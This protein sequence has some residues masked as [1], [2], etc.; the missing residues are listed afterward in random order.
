MIDGIKDLGQNVKGY[1]DRFDRETFYDSETGGILNIPVPGTKGGI[2]GDEGLE[3]A[4]FGE[5]GLLFDPSDPLDYITLGLAATGIGIPAAIGIKALT[6]GNKIRKVAS[7]AGN[8]VDR[9][10]IPRD[11]STIGGKAR[12][13]G[14]FVAA[15]EA[16]G[17]PSTI[18]DIKELRKIIEENKKKELEDRGEFIVTPKKDGGI[19]EGI[20]SFRKGGSAVKQALDAAKK[21]GKEAG[22][23]TNTKKTNTS[24]AD[25]IDEGTGAGAG[26][27]A[28]QAGQNIFQRNKG[29]TIAAGLAGVTAYSLF[30]GGDEE[31]Q[32][33]ISS[34]VSGGDLTYS[35]LMNA[36]SQ[37]LGNRI[38]TVG[39]YMR[40]SLIDD[41]G[42]SRNAQGGVGPLYLADENGVRK[43]ENGI[44]REKPSFGE[45]IKSFG[46]GYGQRVAN[47]PDFAKSMLAGFAAMMSPREGFA[48]LSPLGIPEFTAGYLA[49]EAISDKN[50]S[51]QQKL[52]EAV[53]ED[54][55]LRRLYLEGQAAQGGFSLNQIDYDKMVDIIEETAAREA[56][57]L[58][59]EG[60]DVVVGFQ[61]SDRGFIEMTP[62]KLA[63]LANQDPNI[64]YNL[65][66]IPKSEL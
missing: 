46:K 14:R 64:I 62:N 38:D 52:L 5:D 55:S 60:R 54:P 25:P 29:K 11:A 47:D 53:Q 21:E 36:G 12:N 50:K 23:K 51:A 15:E 44:E 26:A 9:T 1:G 16:V 43:P 63:A 4:M 45:Y 22:K 59:L 31:E 24:K 37:E 32:K 28:G 57:R 8:V 7:K 56:T 33:A 10:F 35:E 65:T 27:D 6:T 61:T 3:L 42:Y 48:P 49:Q 19:I 30:T 18:K 39:E 34:Q 40:E 58:G 66:A 2:F 20:Q 13:F 41:Y 17:A